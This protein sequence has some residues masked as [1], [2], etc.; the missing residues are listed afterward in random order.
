MKKLFVLFITLALGALCLNVS[1]QQKPAPFE[2]KV[3]GQ[4]K[5]TILFIPGLAC[6][7]EVWEETV[8]RFKEDHTCYIFTMAGFA[9]IPGQA[10]P[11]L[12]EWIDTIAGYVRM[13][14][15]EK[16]VIVGHSLGGGMAMALAARYPN[17]FSKIVVVDA[18]PCLGAL[19]NPA[20]AAKEHPDCSGVVAQMTQMDDEHFYKTQ[21]S[22]MPHMMSD[23][24]HLEQVVQWGV[25]SDRKTIATLYCQLSNTDLRNSLSSIQCPALVL[26]EA[27]FSAMKPVI[28]AQYKQLATAQLQF[29]PKGMHF[30]MYDDKEWYLAQLDN[31]LKQ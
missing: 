28:E 31:F 9:G 23:T 3:T 12:Q 8:Q 14:K 4:G 17:L 11:S 2:V 6:S 22:N 10:A 1:A 30:I 27:P 25:R 24:T 18:L 29:A 13:Q 7:G 26:L 16:P 19:M 5:K 20:F 21:R 15:I